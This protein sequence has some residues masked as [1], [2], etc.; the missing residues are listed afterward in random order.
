MAD[1]IEKCKT[2]QNVKNGTLVTYCLPNGNYVVDNTYVKS[3][4]NISHVETELTNRFDD[5]SYYSS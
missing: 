3:Q 5:T 1:V 4:T 2:G